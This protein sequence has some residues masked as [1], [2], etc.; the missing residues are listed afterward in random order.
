MNF[1]NK[2]GSLCS[3]TRRGWR[4][5]SLRWS[6]SPSTPRSQGREAQPL[7]WCPRQCIWLYGD[8]WAYMGMRT[9]GNGWPLVADPSGS[10]SYASYASNFD[11]KPPG[12]EDL[13]NM[14][15]LCS[16]GEFK[17][18]GRLSPRP[19]WEVR[20]FSVQCLHNFYNILSGCVLLAS[21]RTS[22]PS[23]WVF[24]FTAHNLNM[25]WYW[26][27]WMAVCFSDFTLPKQLHKLFF[28]T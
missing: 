26:I 20:F 3:W 23:L 5:S 2:I 22:L 8:I 9:A 10:S 6:C 1:R 18:E 28:L 17:P 14:A 27:L 21:M 13:S 4:S 12:W 11:K 15:C 7:G 16:N 19:A 25:A 24:L